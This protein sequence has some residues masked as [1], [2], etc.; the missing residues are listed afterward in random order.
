MLARC[1]AMQ[2]QS[3]SVTPHD[4][5]PPIVVISAT[6]DDDTPYL[7]GRG[8]LWADLE[9]HPDAKIRRMLSLLPGRLI[10]LD[11]GGRTQWRRHTARAFRV[12]NHI[13]EWT[14]RV[15]EVAPISIDGVGMVRV[16][17]PAETPPEIRCP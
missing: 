7:F 10:R 15:A 5:A 14:S 9:Y 3:R 6:A 4:P 8:M 12:S 2:S 13:G 16:M 11:T 17:P 1:Q